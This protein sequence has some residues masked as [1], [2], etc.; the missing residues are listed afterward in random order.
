MENIIYTIPLDELMDKFKKIVREEV[1]TKQE[2]QEPIN[3]K[4][5]KTA[6]A[7]HM[8]KVSAKTIKN[9]RDS[10]DL[11]FYRIKRNIYFKKSELLIKLNQSPVQRTKYASKK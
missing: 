5:V 11:P 6:Y 9:W 8:F 10:G 4:L 3:E 2:T 1:S 7:M